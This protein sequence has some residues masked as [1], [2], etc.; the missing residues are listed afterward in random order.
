MNLKSLSIIGS[1]SYIASHFIKSSKKTE[2]LKLF[3]RQTSGLQEEILMDDLFEISSDHFHDTDI[4]INFT[5]IVHQP[6]LKDENLYKKINTLL[7]IHFAQEAKKA[8]VKHF[9]QMSSI[10]VYGK[11]S[12]L[13]IN[14]MENPA[15][16][17]GETKLSADKALLA[18]QD[19]NFKVSIIRPP[20]V[21]GGGNAPGN[22][23]KL[24]RFAHSGIPMPFKNVHNTRDFIHV[25][26]LIEA[27]HIVIKHQIKGIIIPTDKRSVSTEEIINLI[28]KYTSKSVKQFKLPKLIL[29]VVKNTLPSLYDKVFGTLK[30]QCNLPENLYQPKYGIEDGLKE[31]VQFLKR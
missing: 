11:V 21:Y 19:E 3:S 2:S 20:M 15:N 8:G 28:K 18:L 31:M 26:N 5:G 4:V 14:T 24:I 25:L 13:D 23:M 1:D 7:P 17:Y 30:V 10:A 6:N 9:I 22:M 12:Y 16:I 29:L 27:I